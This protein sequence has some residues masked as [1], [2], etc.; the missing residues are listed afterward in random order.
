MSSA[1]LVNHPKNKDFFFF[2]LMDVP[3]VYA[4]VQKPKKKYKSEETEWALTAFIDDETREDIE[5]NILLNKELFKVGVDKNKKRKIKYPTSSQRD[6]GNDVYDPYEGM[7]GVSLTL[8]TKR[9]NGE[10]NK[11]VVV[12]KDGN[13]MTDLVGN[14]SVCNIKCFGYRNQDDLLVVS[15]N[16]IQVVDHVPYEGGDGSYE[17]DVLGIT[18]KKSEKVVEESDPV[19]DFE[20][21]DSSPF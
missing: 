13:P 16:L 20:D 7:H 9:K 17:D 19:D 18:V 4:S 1:K 10:D 2:Y 21:G 15:L 11:L 3:V 14:G 5:E 6:D 8:N 12:D